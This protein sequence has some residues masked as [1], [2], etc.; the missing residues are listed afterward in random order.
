MA[1][2]KFENQQIITDL[3]K[4]Q[5][6]LAPLSIKLDRWPMGDNPQTRDLLAKESLDEPEKESVLQEL[7]HY[8]HQLQAEGGYQSRD[9]IVL[10][11]NIPQLDELLSKFAKC[12]TH[13][14]DEVRYIVDGEGIFGF[15][16]S[17]ASQIALK[18]EAGEYINVPKNTEHWFYLTSSRRIKAVRYFTGTEGWVPRYTNTEVRV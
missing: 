3:N 12:H 14:D 17:D 10:H 15:V 16:R 13:D 5:T 8:F 7:D 9:I 11:P 18:V 1:E 2:L 6:E 4:I